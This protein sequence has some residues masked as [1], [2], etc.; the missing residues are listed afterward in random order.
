MGVKTTISNKVICE[1]Y[2]KNVENKPN[3]FLCR[4]CNDGIVRK[5]PPQKGYAN[6]MSHIMTIH[7]DHLQVVESKRK[8]PNYSIF[9]MNPKVVLVFSWLQW[10]V[11]CNLPFTFIEHETTR[12]YSNLKDLDRDT[13]KK[14][15]FDVAV[16]L[17]Q[18]IKEVLPAKFGLILDG[19]SERST[20]YFSLFAEYPN[21]KTNAKETLLLSISPLFDETNSEAPNI[22]SWI[23]DKLGE[24]D[25]NLQSVLYLVGDNE[26]TNPAVANLMRVPFLGCD[27]H[28]LNL[29]LETWQERNEVLI[30]KVAAVM[31]ALGN[32]KNGGILRLS[33]NLQPVI[34]NKTRWSSENQMIKRFQQLQTFVKQ[35]NLP[36][37]FSL[38]PSNLEIVTLT[39]KAEIMADFEV[40]IQYLQ[41]INQSILIRSRGKDYKIGF[42]TF[43]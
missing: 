23:V 12:K 8:D 6:L 24:Y 39:E 25:K 1:V 19:W 21:A 41:G 42:K 18:T 36:E 15:M 32:P 4:S 5:Q 26:N 31:S 43:I 16:E 9:K 11:D 20:K 13:L 37:V 38:M 3:C 35:N 40:V 22:S 34:R 33:T 17:D 10:I 14:W 29:A 7:H 27:S 30:G 2:F 28:R